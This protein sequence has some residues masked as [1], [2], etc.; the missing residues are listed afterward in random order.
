M[1]TIKQF[2]LT[3][4]FVV[5]SISALSSKNVKVRADTIRIKFDYALLEVSTFDLKKNTL[6]KAE[7]PRKINNL[8]A[9][10]ENI[11]ITEPAKGEKITI[12]FTDYIGGEVQEFNRLDLFSEKNSKKSLIFSEGIYLETDFGTFILEIEDENYCIRLH[13]EKLENARKVSSPEFMQKIIDADSEIPENRK[14]INGW[15]IE[16]KNKSFNSYFFGETPPYTLDMLELNAG[17]GTGWIQNQFVSGFNFGLGLSFMKKGI[18]KNKIFAD[19]EMLYNYSGTQD[20]K[21]FTI[22]GFLS[23]GFERNFSLDPNKAKWYG[24][25]AGYLVDRNNAFFEKNTFRIAIHKKISNSIN[26]KPEIYFNDFF[27]NINPALRV[28]VSF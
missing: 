7:I 23:L 4:L 8:L 26:L 25:S 28:Q 10:L 6:E 21:K 14:K 1:Q 16:N 19:Y 2:L 12:H 11:E 18:V 13:L 9:Q 3:I 15:L 27:K 24:F 5:I 20:N 22:N 17:V